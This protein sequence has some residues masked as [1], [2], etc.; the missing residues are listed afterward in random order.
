MLEFFKKWLSG[1]A[2][3]GRN[4]GD[5][6][7]PVLDLGQEV[8][9]PK[10]NLFPEADVHQL[11]IRA[12]SIRKEKGYAEAIKFLKELAEIYLRQENTALVTCVN[13]LVP[14]MKRDPGETYESTYRYLDEL[15][16]RLPSSDPYFLNLHITMA[17][18][19]ETKR[20]QDA[21]HYLET[22]LR[23]HP[24]SPETYYHLIKLGDFYRSEGDPTRARDYLDKAKAF[25]NER[26]H[27]TVLIRMQR[28]W[29]RA[30]ASLAASGNSRKDKAEFLVCRFLEFA[31]DL[32][33]V[34]DPAQIE[35]FHKR[36]DQ[37][38]HHLRG[39]ENEESFNTSLEVLNISDRKDEIIR[40]IYGYVFEEM[41]GIM[42]VTEK[43]LNYKTGDPETL[44]DVREKKIFASRPFTELPAIDSDIRQIVD[45]F[46][47]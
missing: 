4:R 34:L 43:Q 19:I 22:F 40:R 15:L 46:V 38:F 26:F 31:L 32:A 18:L 17:E 35:D 30:A 9:S 24:P 20:R 21:I 39:F 36:K 29:Y 6:N 2:R 23:N 25:W 7:D 3:R 1:N 8:F 41:P 14:Y 10:K 45:H 44:E 16:K 47:L 42:G 11:M 37:Y 33:R 12:T 5:H 28:R 13:K 27:R